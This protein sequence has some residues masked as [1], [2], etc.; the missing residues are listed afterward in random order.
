MNTST[1]IF[2]RILNCT[3]G[4]Y[5]GIESQVIKIN[6]SKSQK[7]ICWIIVITICF[8]ALLVLNLLTPLISDDFS[9]MFIY[10]ENTRIASVS[11][12]VQS[13]INHYHLWGGRSV[14]HFIAQVLLLLPSYI[15]DLVTSVVYMLYVVLIYYHIKGHSKHSLSLFI[16]INLAIWFLQPVFGDTIL[17][18]TGSANYL[19]CTFIILLFLLPYRLYKGNKQNIP[20][21]V[22]SSFVLLVSG[23]IAGWTNENTAGA[24]ILIIILFFFYYRSKNIKIPVWGIC[25]LIGAIAGY[26]ILIFAPGNLERAGESAITFYTVIYRIFNCTLTFFFYSGTAL[27]VC[28]ITFILYNKFHREEKNNKFK[29]SL[30]YF[31]AAIAAVYAMLFSPTFPRRALFG[32]VTFLIIGAGILYYN[33]DFRHRF[34]RQLRMAVIAIGLI[35]FTF[36]FYLA[37]KDINIFR[38]MMLEREAKIDAAKKA[39]ASSCEFERYEGST[40]IHGEDPFSAEL[41]S[42]Y[43]G[44]EIRFKNQD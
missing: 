13:Q 38:N 3:K 20:I 37:A 19:W 6:N 28:L 21:S 29:L 35:C 32:V 1:D 17:W 10:G 15:T 31:I 8:S 5:S 16:V 36:T 26:A 30:I 40:F 11:D 25:G 7:A 14:A 22:L 24:M 23:I 41:M 2:D 9:Y 4:F 44:I 12:I 33:L 42:R 27:L 43:Y 34:L 18:I 39:N